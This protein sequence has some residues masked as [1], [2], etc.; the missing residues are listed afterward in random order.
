[1]RFMRSGSVTL[2]HL[3]HVAIDGY[4]AERRPGDRSFD[5]R[6]ALRARIGLFGDPTAF[7]ISAT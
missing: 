1:M 6:S 2:P 5:P 4:R 3:V 7:S